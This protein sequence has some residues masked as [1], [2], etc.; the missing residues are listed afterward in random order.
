MNE[1]VIFDVTVALSLSSF[2]AFSKYFTQTQKKY[3]KKIENSL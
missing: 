3:A 2:L 1:W